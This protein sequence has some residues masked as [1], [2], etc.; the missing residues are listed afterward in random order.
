MPAY[1]LERAMLA[2]AAK[3]NIR[4]DYGSEVYRVYAELLQTYHPELSDRSY[5]ESL[6]SENRDSATGNEQ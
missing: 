3:Y 4:S 2:A 1:L 5:R 6:G